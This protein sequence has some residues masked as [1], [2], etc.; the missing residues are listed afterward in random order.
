MFGCQGQYDLHGH[1]F[2]PAKSTADGRIDHP[3]LVQGKVH[4]VG[5][6]L[7]VFMRPLAANNHGHP[8]VFIN[9]TEAGFR[10]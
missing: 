8:A 3:H 4:S 7:L 1:I 9:V 6:L 5:N 10:L 2:T